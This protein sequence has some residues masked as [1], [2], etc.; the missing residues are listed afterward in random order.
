MGTTWETQKGKRKVDKRDE[1]L[2]SLY[3]D[4]QME[5]IKTGDSDFHQIANPVTGKIETFW[6]QGEGSAP[7]GPIL[8][9]PRNPGWDKNPFDPVQ[10]Y[11]RQRE[12]SPNPADPGPSAATAPAPSISNRGK[13][14]KLRG[15]GLGNKKSKGRGK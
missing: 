3:Y 5:R 7:Q 12:L 2:W 13:P 15:V 11:E 6:N 4:Q 10:W 8:P 1:Y 14:N 9:P